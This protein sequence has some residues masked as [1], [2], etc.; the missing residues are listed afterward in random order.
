MSLS[1]AI[2]APPIT[3]KDDWVGIYCDQIIVT[4]LDQDLSEI[5]VNDGAPGIMAFANIGKDN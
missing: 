2:S 3:D 1:D 4:S 5:E